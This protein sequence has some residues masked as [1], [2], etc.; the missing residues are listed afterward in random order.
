MKASFLWV[1]F[2][3][4]LNAAAN[5][6]APTGPA[7]AEIDLMTSA[8]AVLVKGAW[9]YSDVGIV[10]T[11]FRAPDAQG[12]PTGKPIR[13]Y[14]YTPHAGVR[15]FDDGAW[16]EIAP[17]SL[18]ER[19]GNGRLSFN[20]YR[21]RIT[22]PERVGGFD[23]RNATLVF[24]TSL[25]DCAEIWVDG[26]LPRA[27][28]QSGGSVVA[29]WNA[30]N[31][32]V[33]GWRVKPGQEI[34]LAIFGMNGPV[35][36]L[37]TNFIWM[38]EA[39]LQFY[40]GVDGPFAVT[41]QEVNVDVE[42]LDPAIDGIVPE[43]AKVFKLAE[44]FTFT[45]GPVYRDGV[46]LFSDP[47]ENRIYRY[48]ANG[49]LSVFREMSGYTGKDIAEYGQPGTNGLTFD[50]QGRLTANEHGNRRVTRTEK[51]GSLTVLADRYQGKR[52]NSP[53]DLVYKSDGTLYFTD[54]PFGLPAFHDDPRRE[55]VVFGVYGVF[56]GRTELLSGD[57]HGPNGLAF[58]PDE[59]YLYVGNWD[60]NRKVV[61]RYPVRADGRLDQGEVFFDMTTAEGEDAIDGVKTDQRGNVYVSGPGGLWIIDASGRHLGTIKTARHPHNFAWGGPDNRTLY[62]TARSGP[63]RIELKVPGHR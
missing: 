35:S 62:L 39:R 50:A 52:L 55:L 57:L 6:T 24:Q 13:T 49:A 1:A 37:P 8:G 54:P 40:P 14:D 4:S 34:Q 22:V 61:M 25:D 47:N 42:R 46:L 60:P 15:D 27:T 16:M 43:N 44:G 33:A 29:G 36:G 48:E 58:S 17:E 7:G 38:R 3:L 5:G 63:Y 23:T 28:G 56:N 18:P 19:R 31:R 11:G 26:E 51:D 45:E 30:L 21:I 2:A 9:R 53:N 41:P 10:E 12:Q 20:W 32:L 59:K